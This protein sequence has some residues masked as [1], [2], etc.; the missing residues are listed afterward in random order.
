MT[1]IYY[2]RSYHD[3]KPVPLTQNPGDATASIPVPREAA[4]VPVNWWHFFSFQEINLT[5][6]SNLSE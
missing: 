4:R 5:K 3:A 6:H 2:F 1:Y